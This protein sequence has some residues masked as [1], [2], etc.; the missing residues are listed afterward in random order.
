MRQ[1]KWKAVRYDVAINPDYP[2]ELYDLTNDP[3]EKNN[4]AAQ[5][6]EIVKEMNSNIR[7]ARIA[8]HSPKFNFPSPRK[9][10]RRNN[11]KKY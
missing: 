4:V 2:L 11:K 10:P 8:S 1:G 9:Q 6:P 3:A 5:Y 7:E